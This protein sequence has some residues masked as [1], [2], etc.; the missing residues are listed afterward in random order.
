MAI[1]LLI[2]KRVR[3]QRVM[4]KP[5]PVLV[6]FSISSGDR[7]NPGRRAL[8]RPHRPAAAGASPAPRRPPRSK[9]NI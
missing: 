6:A 8:S 2:H 7:T 5:V 9:I 3:G 4:A 1:E